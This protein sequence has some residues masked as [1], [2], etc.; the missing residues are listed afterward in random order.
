MRALHPALKHRTHPTNPCGLPK[1]SLALA[2]EGLSIGSTVVYGREKVSGSKPSA[3][4]HAKDY[5]IGA[6]SL[7]SPLSWAYRLMRY[8]V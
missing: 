1:A 3:V 7:P 2:P 5:R 8:H 4:Y 6:T